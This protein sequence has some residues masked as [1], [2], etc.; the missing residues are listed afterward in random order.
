MDNF[1]EGRALRSGDPLNVD[2]KS[3]IVRRDNPLYFKVQEFNLEQKNTGK[4][5]EPRFK[6]IQDLY[7][8]IDSKLN[9]MR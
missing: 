9:H 8:L 1:L 6:N 3:K 2:R 5:G 4:Q 7:M